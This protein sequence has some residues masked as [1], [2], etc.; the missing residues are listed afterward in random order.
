MFFAKDNL[1]KVLE[2]ALDAVVS[3][4]EK[5]GI[6]FFNSSAEKLWGYQRQ[7][8]IG[9]NV[10]ILVP[11]DIKGAHDGYIQRN[12]ETGEDKI[13]GIS[14]DVLM[15]RKDGSRVWAN[16]SLSKVIEGKSI[17]YTA[18][19]RDISQERSTR[20]IINQTLEQAL[21]AVVTIDEHNDITFA[22]AAAEELWGYERAEMLGQNVKML[23]PT[24]IRDR[25]DDMVNAN[26]RTN[27][28]KIVG[29]TREVPVYRK[30]CV[31][32]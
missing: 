23:V 27:V 3:I 4:D 8:V 10:K 25:H 26:R 15:T 21:D 6:T 2:Q 30:D 5:N 12:R 1:K 32:R 22:N 14:R 19:V 17:T 18:F 29:T 24:D 31:N 9:K 28:D 13:V 11:D 20:E 7:E 16:L